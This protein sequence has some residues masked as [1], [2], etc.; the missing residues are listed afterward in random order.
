M[1]TPP[2]TPNRSGKGL[3]RALGDFL[4]EY[5]RHATPFVWTKGPAKLRRIIELTEEFQAE[6]LYG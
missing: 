4:N 3:T 6:H 2:V 5:N 1:T